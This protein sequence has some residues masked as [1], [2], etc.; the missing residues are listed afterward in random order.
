MCD[1]LNLIFLINI[2]EPD[3]IRDDQGCVS[4]RQDARYAYPGFKLL[5]GNFEV[6]TA[7]A[8]LAR[9]WKS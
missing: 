5:A 6:F 3:I 8:M 2:N 9:S 4:Y 1:G 7:R